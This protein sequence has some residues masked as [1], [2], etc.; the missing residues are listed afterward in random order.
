[1]R[2]L[3][4]IYVRLSEEDRDKRCASDESESIQNQKSMLINYCME[5]GWQINRIL[6]DEDYSGADRDRPA[7]KELLKDCEERRVDI[8]LCKTQSRFSRD[9]EIVEKYIHGR[10]LEWNIRFVSVVDHA[11]TS[12]EGNKKARQINGLI[13]EWYLEDLSDN[14][15]KTLYHKKIKGEYCCPYA[16]YGYKLD[17]EDKHHFVID[18]PAAEVVRSI[19]EMYKS[20]MGYIRIAKALN[21]KQIPPPVVY[22]SM[23]GINYRNPNAENA[24]EPQWRDSSIYYILRQEVYTGA[25]VQGKS[26]NLSYKNKKRVKL[27]KDEWIVVPNM[28]EPIIDKELWDTVQGLLKG[29][30]GKDKLFKVSGSDGI[31]PLRGIMYC[32]E[33]GAGMWRMSYQCADRRY[34]YY[35]CRTVKNSSGICDNINSVRQADIEAVILKELQKLIDNYFNP[36]QIKLQKTS[37]AESVLV[38]AETEKRQLDTRMTKLKNSSVQLYKDK[39]NGLLDD[40]QFKLLNDSFNAEL[41]Q[42]EER[43]KLL[44]EKIAGLND[45]CNKSRSREEILQ[46]YRNVEGLCFE[47]VQEMIEGVYVGKT[48]SETN[49]REIEIHW[50]F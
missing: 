46:R 33:C 41:R 12:V 14:I 32:K 24:Y 42:M 4:D 3:A 36:Q 31:N 11:D 10:F 38:A 26:K 34:K 16:P 15:R 9:M 30:G 48:N 17:P 45:K 23:Q 13:N 44:D 49:T 43:L 20:G 39:L 35:R 27:P 37:T 29:H 50:K 5:Q 21:E 47:L 18:P 25:V 7:F 2:N 6:C 8:V 19:F 40:E 28:H 22:K 1:M